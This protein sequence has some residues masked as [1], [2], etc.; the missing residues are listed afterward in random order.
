M[1]Q[2]LPLPYRYE[3]EGLEGSVVEEW[4]SCENVEREIL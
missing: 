2:N 3:F 4:D 1:L